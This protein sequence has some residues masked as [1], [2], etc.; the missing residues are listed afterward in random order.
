MANQKGT[1][2]R[3]RNYLH[4]SFRS[5]NDEICGYEF[6]LTAIEE[7]TFVSVKASQVD[8]FKIRVEFVYYELYLLVK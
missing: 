4:E 1:V 6:A 5:L 8:T 2:L 3:S 7:N